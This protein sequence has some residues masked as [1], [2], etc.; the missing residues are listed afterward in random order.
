[1]P[2]NIGALIVELAANTARFETD[3]GRAARVAKARAREIDRAFSRMG[4]SLTRV[5]AGLAGAFSVSAI[6]RA[7]AEAEKAMGAL[8]HAVKNNAG[9]AKL[10]APQLAAMAS[11]LQGLTTYGD[12]AIMGMQSLLLTFRQIGGPEFKR[13][14]AAVLDLAT[15]LG[16]DLD[17]AA[18][19]VGRALADP[20]KG[21]TALSRAGFV[22]GKDQ[23]ELIKHLAE[24]GRLTE[25]QGVLLDELEKSYG[26]AAEA[27]RNTFAGALKGVSNAFNDLL[28]AKGGLPEATERLNDLARLLQDPQTVAGINAITS[29]LVTGFTAA[30]KAIAETGNFMR[31]I[32][33]AAAHALHGADTQEGQLQ[34][35]LAEVERRLQAAK[36]ISQSIT[37]LAL[38]DRAT[39]SND[40]R[41][42]E[43][44]AERA[45]IEDK[46]RA[47]EKE[48]DTQALL[49]T[50]AGKGGAATAG[51]SGA[52]AAPAPPSEEF[53]KLAANLR[54]QIALYGKT[55]EAAKLAY[56]L[57]IGGLDGVSEAEGK[58]LLA[59][60]RQYDAMVQSNEAAKAAAEAR[61]GAID[62]LSKMVAAAEQEAATFG[63]D[64][65]AV[66]E[67][68]LAHGDLAETLKAGGPEAQAYAA[69]LLELTRQLEAMDNAARQAAD[70]AAALQKTMDDGK[71][72]IEATRT[73]LEKYNDEIERLNKL[74]EA[75]ALGS[76]SDEVY[77]RAVE[78][79]QDAF[80]K[81]SQDSS[82]FSEQF[83]DGVFRSLGDGIYTAMTDGAKKGWKGFLEAG[84]DTIDRLVAQ[85]L[86]KRL[87][88]GLFGGGSGDPNAG[89]GG[90]FV[91]GIVD[92][93][94]GLFGG[95][96]AYGGEVT[97]GQLYRVQE[98]G[99]EFF[100]PNVSG[101]IIPLSKMPAAAG[102]VQIRQTIQVTGRVDAR[103]AQQLA[104]ET[105]RRQRIQM[106]RLG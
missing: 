32:G 102:G 103:T 35:Q 62:E 19:M 25:A 72:V 27:A 79:A 59:L 33:E 61:Q 80:H 105:A 84:L 17:T 58:Q 38:L 10:T 82:A 44:E 70:D 43:L 37:P 83:K 13:A 48:A 9:A 16:Q 90:G 60:A 28:E 89:G 95:G 65:A 34:D 15:V 39:G 36:E 11:E 81:A 66:L 97:A 91:G 92:F 94:G 104:V 67:Y 88:D 51:V 98:R 73:P 7:T 3:T 8:E 22:L 54:E 75:G 76:N 50:R 45:A 18:K 42:R 46:I 24:T 30:A 87:A 1:M 40:R 23:Q 20:V 63:K 69:R 2:S 47:M 56:Q 74:K 6:V 93:F 77:R 85:A 96:R 12:E 31:F 99:Q 5:F 55:G 78:A 53:E 71:S 57:Q 101:E 29:A 49:E 4:S 14:Q 21:M 86:A 68:R 100:R 26:G 52:A 64:A 41:I 106:A